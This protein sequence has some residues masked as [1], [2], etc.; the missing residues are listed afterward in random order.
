LRRALERKV[1]EDTKDH[2]KITTLS[3]DSNCVDPDLQDKIDAIK[4]RLIE[5]Y[6]Y[7]RQSAEDVLNY[8]S[9]IFSRGDVDDND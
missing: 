7:N 3:S 1:Y 2:I 4:T 6:G 9:G 5:Q 8:V